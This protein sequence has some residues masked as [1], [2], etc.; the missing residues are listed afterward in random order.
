[1][2]IL[3]KT[4]VIYLLIRDIIFVFPCFI[5][6]I[7]GMT[8]MSPDITESKQNIETQVRNL[9]IHDSGKLELLLFASAST[10]QCKN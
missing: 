9:D 6:I 8:I 1:M 2:S 7:L 3:F 5:K 4:N 10:N